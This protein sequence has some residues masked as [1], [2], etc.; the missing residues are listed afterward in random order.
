MYK[1]VKSNLIEII[2]MKQYQNLVKSKKFLQALP[3]L[4]RS[5]LSYINLA[6]I[7]LHFH[8]DKVDKNHIFDN[9]T[10][11][12]I[13]ETYFSS[14]KKRSYLSSKLGSNGEHL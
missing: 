12:D 2:G 3:F 5:M 1:K 7:G 13:Y 10:Y 14:L 9:M 6:D 4:I 11:L 8:T